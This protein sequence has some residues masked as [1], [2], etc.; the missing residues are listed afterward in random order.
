METKLRQETLKKNTL[1]DKNV[2]AFI[3]EEKEE[4][5]NTKPQPKAQAYEETKEC[6]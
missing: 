3:E 1:Q 6:L 5:K 4:T 2:H